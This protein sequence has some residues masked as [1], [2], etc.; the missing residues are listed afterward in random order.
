MVTEGDGGG[1]A[2]D[3]GPFF[4][5]PTKMSDFQ[6]CSNLTSNRVFLVR[7]PKKILPSAQK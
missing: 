4:E 2:N 6:I 3:L 5:S 7:K 1:F